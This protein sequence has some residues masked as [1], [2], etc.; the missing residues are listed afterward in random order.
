MP[1]SDHPDDL[2]LVQFARDPES[3]SSEIA[4][5]IATCGKCG[6]AIAFER[7]GRDLLSDGTD[8][9]GE[10]STSSR[11]TS[12]LEFR[13]RIA[14]EDEEADRLLRD[15]INDP[16]AFIG[17][18]LLRRRH[19]YTGGVVR[20]LTAAARDWTVRD[21]KFALRLAKAATFIADSLPNNYYPAK[22]VNDIR[23]EAWKERGNVCWQIGTYGDALEAADR[24]EAAY[25]ITQAP[26]SV[27]LTTVSVLRASI[28][29]KQQRFSEALPLI[30]TASS[31]YQSRRDTRRY[32]EAKETE[33]FILLRM[34]RVAAARAAFVKSYEMADT[35]GSVEMKARAAKNIAVTSREAGDLGG[36]SQYALVALRLYEELGWTLMALRARWLILQISLTAGNAERVIE[37]LRALVADFEKRGSR[38]DAA[39]VQLDI[40]EALIALDRLEEVESICTELIL[41]YRQQNIITN[42]LI[43]VSFLKEVAARRVITPQHV[44]HVRHYLAERKE[45]PTLVFA[46]PN[47]SAQSC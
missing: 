44:Q 26:G 7:T 17:R 11:A 21:A 45:N 20:K 35:H 39:D 29:S 5:H 43:A 13:R 36:A 6:R 9:V 33:A 10:T 2:L 41:Y 32:L 34:G 38:D 15:F 4:E 12:A 46:P 25:K 22:A 19:F 47:A 37:P 30:V 42:A 1:L 16:Y 31:I 27:Q 14:A 23:G 28:L 40:A 3:V 8:R 18:R 24:A